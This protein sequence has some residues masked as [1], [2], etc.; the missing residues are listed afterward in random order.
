MA[1]KTDDP[2][3]QLEK[4]K[5]EIL[6][7]AKAA[8]AIQAREIALKIPDVPENAEVLDAL[9]S[10]LAELGVDIAVAE[11]PVVPELTDEWLIE[12]DE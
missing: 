1:P 5:A 12:D 4:A 10:E 6:E 8:G 7:Q 9:Y 2:K 11:E 3:Q